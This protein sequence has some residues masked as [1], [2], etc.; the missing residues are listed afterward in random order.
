[1]LREMAGFTSGIDNRRRFR[2][3][4]KGL[5]ERFQQGYM[6]KHPPLGYQLNVKIE[7]G[8][9]VRLPRVIVPEE[10]RTV[11]RIYAEYK[12]GRSYVFIARRLNSEA[13]QS[14]A[15]GLWSANVVRSVIRNPTYCGK[16]YRA[17][18]AVRGKRKMLPDNKWEIVPGK[19]EPIIPESLWNEVQEIRRRK[20]KR[21]RAVGSS[22]LLSGILRCGYCG[23]SMCNDGA[24]GGGYYICG[25]Y[26]Q[27]SSCR[28][29]SYRR[30][31]LERD[32]LNYIFNVLR[33]EDLYEEAVARRREE[34]NNDLA[35][36]V[37]RLEMTLAEFPERK[38][39][40]FDLYERDQIRREEFLHR[41]D[42]H[43]QTEAQIA[44]AL[45]Q[46]QTALAKAV[47]T[48]LTRETFDEILKTL[49]EQWER[50]DMAV[51]KQK[52]SSLIEKIMIQEGAFKIHFR[53]G[54]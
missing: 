3:L 13:V 8:K 47:S 17:T 11:R 25:Q 16:V 6:Q 41:K 46:K 36:E 27:M 24:W 43:N 38:R 1:M 18:I 54:I 50:C 23:Y 5:K 49:E 45:E 10:A 29:N 30:I 7:A 31:H 15:G 19:H 53:T 42:E 12:E 28:R 22:L 39:R 51:R 33:N 20:V 26:K 9:V 14:P 34:S 44:G 52:L 40:L 37:K 48:R 4:Q 2:T 32:V 21:T 35:E